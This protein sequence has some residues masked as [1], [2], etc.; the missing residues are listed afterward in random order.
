MEI[1]VKKAKGED[2]E[3]HDEKK[4]LFADFVEESLRFAKGTKASS[5]SSGNVRE[6]Q[7]LVRSFEGYQSMLTTAL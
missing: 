2:L 1:E 7:R 6:M 4:S 5:T 3:I